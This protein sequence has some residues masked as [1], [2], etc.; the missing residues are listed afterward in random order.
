MLWARCG[1][2]IAGYGSETVRLQVDGGLMSISATSVVGGID[3]DGAF[4]VG[5]M[6]AY[7]DIVD[8]FKSPATKAR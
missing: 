2:R 7:R 1:S 6:R 5:D 4:R 8:S 3:V